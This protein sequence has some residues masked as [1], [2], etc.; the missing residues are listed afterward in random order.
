MAK[1][2]LRGDRRITLTIELL[3]SLSAADS[4]QISAAAFAREHGI[5]LD[6]VGEL[7]ELAATLADRNSGARAVITI[8][9][10]CIS[11]EG[12]AAKLHPTRLSAGEGAVL[13]YALD[14]LELDDDCKRR[15]ERALMPFGLGDTVPAT[16]TSALSVGAFYQQLSTAITDGV[17]CAMRYRSARDAAP[18]PRTIDPLSFE[19]TAT[20]AYLL[21]WDVDADAERRYRL[22]RI[23]DVSFT[24]DS[25]TVHKTSSHKLADS[26]AEHGTLVELTMPSDIARDLTWQGI[27]SRSYAEDKATVTVAVTSRSWLFDQLLSLGNGA[28]IAKSPELQQEFRAYAKTLLI[29]QG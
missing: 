16:V 23:A 15:I 11:L 26:L 13:A 6:D 25:V 22:D 24:E 1:R 10:D 4:Q 28:R 27:V 19:T 9:G 5:G 3:E 29:G 14:L 17:R 18:T 8:E 7:A 2:K 12:T 20:A 21:A